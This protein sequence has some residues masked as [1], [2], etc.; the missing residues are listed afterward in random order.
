MLAIAVVACTAKP[1]LD[2]NLAAKDLT[3]PQV[4]SIT[5]PNGAT[6]VLDKPTIVIAFNE[7]MDPGTLNSST[8]TVKTANGSQGIGSYEYDSAQKA[9]SIKIVQ[10]LYLNTAYTVTV[11]SAV[12][13]LAGN[14]IMPVTSTFTTD[15]CPKSRKS[16]PGF[17]G[18]IRAMVKVG[19]TL[20]V[21]GDF[22]AVGE[23]Y[24]YGVGLDSV[25]GKAD[26][27]T[28]EDINGT[29]WAAVSDGNGGWYIGGDFTQIGPYTRNRLAHIL[30]NGEISPWNPSAN[31][32]VRALALSGSTVY[33]GG[34]FTTIGGAT[35]N[36]LA[37]IGTDG[38]LQSWNPN[39]DNAVNA[40]AVSGTT[41][42][43]GGSF[44]SI[45][46][47]TRNRLA[48]IG[49]DGSLQ[50]WNPNAGGTVNALAVIGMTVY[51]GGAFTQIG[52]ISG[53]SITG[54]PIT[55]NRLAAI[56]TDGS[57][58]PWN[59]NA[60]G[61]VNALAVIGTTV[62]A[63]G[64]FTCFGNCPSGTENSTKWTR[65]CLA[66]IGTDGTIQSWNPDVGG[67]FPTVNA[68]AVSGS[69]VYAGGDFTTIG[70]AARNRLAAIDIGGTCLTSYTSGCRLNW[71]PNADGT[72]RALAVSG[73]TVYA[74][75]SFTTISGTPRNRLAAIH[76]DGSLQSWHPN[77][78]GTVNALAV[79]GSTVYAGGSFTCFGNCPS[80]TE[81]VDKWTRNRLAAIHTDG[82]I[83]P[84]NPDV[85][86]I[87]PTVNALAVSGS[88]VYAGGVFTQ[89]GCNT[90]CSITGGPFT[91]NYLAAIGTD[92]S[93]KSWNP[94]AS[95]PVYALA[96][97]G[98]TVYAGGSFTCFGNCPSGTEGVDKWTRNS[99]AAIDIGGTCLTSYNSSCLKSWDPS[100]SNTVSALTVSGSTVYV[101]GSFTSTGGTGRNRLAAIDIGGTCLTA[102]M[103]SCLHSWDPGANNNVNALAMSGSTVYA[104][105]DF[106][107]IGG[108]TRNRLAA[109]HTD[110][111]LQSW[112][113][114]ASSTVNA[115]AVSSSTVYA[116]G[117]FTSI[118][119]I[120]RNRIVSINA[121]G[122]VN[123]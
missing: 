63:G 9:L 69:T 4:V 65:N 46:G 121:D 57:L 66:A 73:T 93:L 51:A 86:G 61:T 85:G 21:G 92:G 80:G 115:L 42:Y 77:A 39:A 111:S 82:T 102:Y 56:G 123:W 103:P 59:P 43:V 91:R 89:I 99:L 71:N 107:S 100:A 108:A 72:V 48:A 17:N 33:A 10:S 2:V 113:P 109:I 64:S 5:P 41:V 13:D 27:F 79:T 104:G 12:K 105:G 116:G 119:G 37:A 90:G 26:G 19:C 20:Y 36:R 67:I 34:D 32:V 84:W 40:L 7:D 52:C 94:N 87:F 16:K 96:V 25:T 78:G 35:R 120:P 81:G 101:G 22:T 76:T 62:Y 53:C 11:T 24:A 55:R 30:G 6:E 97:S 122:S 95:G 18:T 38:S 15:V 3:P 112:D 28:Y 8:V 45:G 83:Q 49:T 118:G 23:A 70:G 47:Q 106:T 88:T 114:N 29:V 74:G 58:Q 50:P 110:G 44:T 31:A 60:G 54:G 1:T 98:S 75:G 14:A 117:S 68:L